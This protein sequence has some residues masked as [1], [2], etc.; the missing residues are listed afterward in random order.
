[1]QP[2][3]FVHA[4]DLQQAGHNLFEVFEVRYVKDYLH[5]GLT[6]GS[7]GSDVADVALGV[8]DN[9]GDVFQHSEAIVAVNSELDRVR[10]GRAFVAGPLY[11]DAAFRLIHEVGDVGAAYG[12]DRDSFSTRDIADNALSANR[13]ATARAVDQHI[14]LAFDHDGVV[15]AKDAPDHAGDSAGLV[16]ESLS[17]D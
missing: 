6:V 12:V 15:I 8:A 4:G 9:A 11:V 13:I 10:C 14:A 2:L 7:V 17:F 1:M 5:A 16:G 3:H